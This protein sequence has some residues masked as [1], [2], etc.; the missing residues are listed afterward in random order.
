MSRKIEI[1]GN[2]LAEGLN[3]LLLA[4]IEIILFLSFLKHWPQMWRIA[5]LLVVPLF[6]YVLREVCANV[7]LFMAA[8]IIP[9]ILVAGW[10]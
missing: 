8:H 2:V 4:M 7:V 10:F 5:L 1:V 3:Y 9:V 6:Y